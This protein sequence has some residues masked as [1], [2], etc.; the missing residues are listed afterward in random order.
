MGEYS[1]GK[2]TRNHALAVYKSGV[3][4]S[5][6]T[7]GD[8]SGEA[9]FGGG[10][11]RHGAGWQATWGLLSSC[12]G[13][14]RT[15]LVWSLAADSGAGVC[16]EIVSAVWDSVGRRRLRHWH[17]GTTWLEADYGEWLSS[18]GL[19]QCGASPKD[20]ASDY[21]GFWDSGGSLCIGG[22][23][24]RCRPLAVAWLFIEALGSKASLPSI[25]MAT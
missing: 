2:A 20:G 4:R 17:R 15:V 11:R 5:V 1:K 8:S 13:G 3:L 24:R 18:A 23:M 6:N 16:L 12:G 10:T 21:L 7:G 14:F 25:L 22:A 19:L 9:Y